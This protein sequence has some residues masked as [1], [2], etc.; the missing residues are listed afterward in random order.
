MIIGEG[1]AAVFIESQE[2]RN[3]VRM[4]D[5]EHYTPHRQ[6]QLSGSGAREQQK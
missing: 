1:K 6:I 2:Q 4:M 5:K 3:G